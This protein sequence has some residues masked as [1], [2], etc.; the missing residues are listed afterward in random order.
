MT[1]IQIFKGNGMKVNFKLK[2]ERKT[3]KKI[4]HNY[5]NKGYNFIFK[6]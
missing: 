5:I 6:L 3:L 4:R 1:K 2:E